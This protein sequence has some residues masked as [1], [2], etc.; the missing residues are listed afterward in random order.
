MIPRKESN[1]LWSGSSAY[2]LT[3]GWARMPGVMGLIW[4][5]G[6]SGHCGYQGLMEWG[7]CK[8]PKELGVLSR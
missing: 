1:W 7:R 2:P 5:P 6:G 4:V 8:Y 3:S